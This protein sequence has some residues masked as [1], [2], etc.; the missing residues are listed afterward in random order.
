MRFRDTIFWKNYDSYDKIV[1]GSSMRCVVDAVVYWKLLKEFKFKK[2][3]E[4]GVYQGLTSGL[5][6]ESNESGTLLGIDPMLRLSNF[7]SF[8]PESVK[9]RS[10]F[11]EG[12]SQ[13]IDV[14]GTYDFILIDGDH[15]V[16]GALEDMLK[17]VPLLEEHGVLA[18]D[19]FDKFGLPE[20][21]PRLI[22]LGLVPFLQ[23]EQTEFWHYP[24]INRSKFL[25]GLLTD[26]IGNFIFIY[27][28]DRFGNTVLKVHTIKLLT[29]HINFF[30]KALQIYN[31]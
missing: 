6:L 11:I 2:F 4:I 27:N 14:S 17:F 24:S 15:S 1:G 3:L 18:I 30:D 31:V 21:V 29:D 10:T 20:V 23:A 16:D 22:D 28:I 19:D 8:Y 26:S 7:N 5:M 13:N 9:Q 25:D 12:L